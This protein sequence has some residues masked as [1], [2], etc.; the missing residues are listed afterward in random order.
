MPTFKT[1]DDQK[2]SFFFYIANEAVFYYSMLQLQNYDV[3]VETKIQIKT[4]IS[5]G[6]Y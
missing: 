1:Q 3:N 4:H 6:C 2:F 5:L